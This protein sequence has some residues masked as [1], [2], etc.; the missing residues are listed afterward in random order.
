MKGER[1][2]VQGEFNDEV[3]KAR[4]S[5]SPDQKVLGAEALTLAAQ[6]DC[7]LLTVQ[8]LKELARGL[9][10]KVGR[11]ESATAAARRVHMAEVYREDIQRFKQKLEVEYGA[12]KL[13]TTAERN[14]GQPEHSGGLQSQNQK[15]LAMRHCT[16]I[17]EEDAA[18]SGEAV[19]THAAVSSSKRRR[20]SGVVVKQS[21]ESE[22]PS[23][24]I[25]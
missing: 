6:G 13:A 25:Q 15:D 4:T 2:K 21:I 20:I 22:K 17:G 18:Q 14:R 8:Q 9:G 23:C 19:Q 1:R 5:S 12:K 7:S 3:A 24:S 16:Q 10:A 11:V